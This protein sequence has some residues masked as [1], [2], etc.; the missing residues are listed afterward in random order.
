MRGNKLL[1]FLD[2]YVGIPLLGALSLIGRRSKKRD[3]HDLAPRRILLVKFVAL[4]D[5]VLLVPAI[6]ALRK[7]FPKAEISFVGTTLTESFL[8]GFPEYIDRFITVDIGSLFRSPAYAASILSSIRSLKCDIAIDFEQ[9]P[10]LSA[11]LVTMG[12]IP[13][14]IGFRTKNQHRHAGF[15]DVVDR[16][17][18]LHEAD[19]FLAL[20]ELLTGEQEPRTLDIKVDEA[21]LVKAQSFLAKH[22]WQKKAPLVIV[23]PGCG[24]HGF[25]REW[26]PGNYAETINRLSGDHNLFIVVSG[27][28]SE[29]TVTSSVRQG[30]RSAVIPYTIQSPD[31]FVA[32]LSLSSLLISG[33]NGAMHLAAALQIPQIALHGPTN[34]RQWGPINTRAVVIQSRCP[35]CPCLDLGF[36]YH[37][38]DGYCMEQIG[39]EDVY[40]ATKEILGRVE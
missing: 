39:M 36:E 26:P 31:D 7:K 24:A 40:R 16:D 34:A 29:S 35:E 1:K 8:R 12:G 18:E 10:R 27:T 2:Y 33:N 22:G 6:R 4:G 14:R 11:I 23:H 20:I 5:A 32:L 37:R 9:W 21:G 17:P 15:T 19:N 3:L 38:Y 25:P 30:I 28:E 13:I